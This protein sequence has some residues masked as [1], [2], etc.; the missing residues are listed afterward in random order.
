MLINLVIAVV[1]SRLTPP[2]PSYVQDMVE[3]IRIPR[4][5]GTAVDH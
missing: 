1:V 4:G 3:D 5:A 2:P